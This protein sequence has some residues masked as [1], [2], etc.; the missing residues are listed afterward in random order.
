MARERVSAAACGGNTSS[1][2]FILVTGLKTW[3]PRKRSG[4]PVALASSA[5]ESEDVVVERT[6]SSRA[7]RASSD[8]SAALLGWSSTTASTRKLVP[9][10]ASNS[11]TTS[12]FPAAASPSSSLAQSFST[13]ALARSA[14]LSE[15]AH[16]TTSPARAAAAASPQAITPAPAMP[17]VSCTGRWSCSWIEPVTTMSPGTV[18][19]RSMS[20]AVA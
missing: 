18:R 15:R 20:W 4:A 19:D 12:I 7:K 6:A 13:R 11:R 14:E 10:R 9:E 17:S 16:R 5:I 1:T 2:S 8:R 3:R